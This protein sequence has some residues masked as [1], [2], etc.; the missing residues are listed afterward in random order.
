MVVSVSGQI[1]CP[2]DNTESTSQEKKQKKLRGLSLMELFWMSRKHSALLRAEKHIYLSTW[3]KSAEMT[4]PDR[5]RCI[6]CM[7]LK[8]HC[9]KCRQ[10]AQG[11][12]WAQTSREQLLQGGAETSRPKNWADVTEIHRHQKVGI[13][14]NF[15]LGREGGFC[16]Q[17]RSELWTETDLTELF[18]W[19]SD[20]YNQETPGNHERQNSWY[21]ARLS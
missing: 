8:E 12:K 16:V 14:C 11:G 20:A 19:L 17:W 2:L 6:L 5:F 3:L 10:A 7:Q 13:F 15:F 1:F 18:H 4:P 21:R 9:G